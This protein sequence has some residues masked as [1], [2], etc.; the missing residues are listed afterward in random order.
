MLMSA[1]KSRSTRRSSS[2]RAHAGRQ[3][4]RPS[5]TRCGRTRPIGKLMQIRVGCELIYEC[6]QPTPMILTLNIHYTRVSDIVRPRSPGHDPVAAD[7]RLSR[8]LRQ[9]VHAASSRRRGTRIS[10]D[11]SDQRQ[12]PARCRRARR[13][14][15]AGRIAA[16]GNADL[17][18]RQPLL[19]DRT[20]AAESRGSCFGN[21][22]TGW[23]R[24]Q[25]ICDFVHNH[26]TF[27]Y[28]HA[29]PTKTAWEAYQRAHAACAATTRTS[30]S[31]SAAA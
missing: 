20:P 9:L 17:S 18:A 21:A 14:A 3:C 2:E 1:S 28:E 31:P 13:E 19:R 23:G 8:F 25:A 5:S 16:R 29:R 4:G 12:R 26:I 22:P 10:A 6:P 11:A 30:R 15:D 24:V 27:G 7:Q